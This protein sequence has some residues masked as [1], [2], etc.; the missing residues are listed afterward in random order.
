MHNG[1]SLVQM[2]VNMYPQLVLYLYNC[3]TCGSLIQLGHISHHVLVLYM[4]CAV[5]TYVPLGKCSQSILLSLLPYMLRFIHV[6]G[7][8]AENKF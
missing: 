2:T 7:F 1:F 8:S 6:T 3:M 5:W 4:L